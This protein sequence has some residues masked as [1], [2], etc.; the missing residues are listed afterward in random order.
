[1][2]LTSPSTGH[3]PPTGNVRPV[4]HEICQA[5]QE[6]VEHGKHSM[7]D[8]H[9][10]PFSAADF[11]Q[12]QSFLG[13]GEVDLT[14][15]VLGKT[16]IRESGY[17]GVWHIEHFT[18]DQQRI[19]YFIEVGHVPEILRSQCDDVREGLTTMTAILA[20]EEDDEVAS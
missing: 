8:L 2:S 17:A 13:T 3:S 6:L 10:L 14:L 11:D 15:N 20:M 9:S 18:D 7:I 4:L 12:I 16:R 5:L 1:M 19:G